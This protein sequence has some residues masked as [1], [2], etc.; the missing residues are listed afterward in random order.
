M[1]K[2]DA[3]HRWMTERGRKG[4]VVFKGVTVLFAFSILV[5]MDS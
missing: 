1:A 4:D 2:E 3:P 5:T